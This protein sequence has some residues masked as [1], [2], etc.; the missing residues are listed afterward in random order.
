IHAIQMTVRGGRDTQSPRG[1]WLFCNAFADPLRRKLIS[2]CPKMRDADADECVEVI[3]IERAD[4]HSSLE[5]FDGDVRF[6]Q[7][8]SEDPTTVPSPSGVRVER[9]GPLHKRFCFL[10]PAGSGVCRP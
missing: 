3:W 10:K 8:C 1:A 7:T 2:A 6:T 9:Q 5:V 4:A